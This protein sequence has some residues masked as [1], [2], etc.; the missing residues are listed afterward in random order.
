VVNFFASSVSSAPRTSS[1]AGSRFEP[2]TLYAEMLAL[3][4]TLKLLM[5]AQLVLLLFLGSFWL[6][7]QM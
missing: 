1:V 7:G 5:I 4:G 2:L 3:S 6:Y